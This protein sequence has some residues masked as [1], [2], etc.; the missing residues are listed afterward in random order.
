M[1]IFKPAI[2]AYYIDKSALFTTYFNCLLPFI[3]ILGVTSILYTYAFALL[4]TTVPSFLSDPFLKGCLILLTLGYY[5]QWY[6]L[7][8]YVYCIIGL[9][10]VILM[11]VLAY[12][13]YEDRPGLKIDFGHLKKQGLTGMMKYGLLLSISALAGLGLKYM[14]A[15]M[16]AHYQPLEIVGIYAVA[17]LVPTVIEA[18]LYALDKIASSRIA[19]A[20][21]S[22]DMEEIKSIYYKSSQYLLLLGGLLFLGININILYIY[23]LTAKDFS[24]GI[25]VVLIISIGTLINMATGVNDAVLFNSKKYIY[26]TYLLLMLLTLAIINNIIF[27]PRFG[28]EGAALATVLSSFV[29]NTVK[30]FFIWRTFRLQPFDMKTLWTLLLIVGCFILNLLLPSFHGAI[31]NI[32]FRSTVISVVYLTGAYFLNIAPELH[33]FVPFLKK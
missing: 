20:Y 22:G 17:A 27:I 6:D 4:K 2:I 19:Y 10:A 8:H 28:M 13:Y 23:E 5:Y 15:I 14:D 24:S 7:D 26:G 18:P 16:L 31:I 3:F 21:A 30:Y 25:N 11:L 32:L 12:I 9:H 33:R 1:W 29:F